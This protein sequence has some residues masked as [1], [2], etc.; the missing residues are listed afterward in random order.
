MAQA[1]CTRCFKAL[2]VNSFR[3]F[4]SCECKG[5][6]KYLP[7]SPFGIVKARPR[8]RAE[9]F[10]AKLLPKIQTLRAQN[11]TIAKDAKATLS[12]ASSILFSMLPSAAALVEFVSF[13]PILEDPCSMGD[14]HPTH[15]GFGM[16]EVLHSVLSVVVSGFPKLSFSGSVVVE[17]VTRTH[18][19][20]FV[21]LSRLRTS[22]HL[23]ALNVVLI[24]FSR[25]HLI[26]VGRFGLMAPRRM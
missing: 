16:L 20:G 8:F 15:T 14:L 7:I 5:D 3:T 19:P 23:Q 22:S 4:E 12:E 18:L 10:I 25:V 21:L 17:V 9:D 24:G 6:A 13:T 2:P 1:H 11:S 26:M